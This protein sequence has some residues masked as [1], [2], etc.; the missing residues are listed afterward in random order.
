MLSGLFTDGGL[1]WLWSRLLLTEREQDTKAKQMQRKV[2]S[3]KSL[4]S[5]SGHASM[6]IPLSF[7]TSPSPSLPKSICRQVFDRES[8]WHTSALLAI[9]MESISL[10]SRLYQFGG[11]G[12]GSRAGFLS[13]IEAVLN[14]NGNQKI[15]SVQMSIADPATLQ[16]REEKE[17]SNLGVRGGNSD[18]R[19]KMQD[20]PNKESDY[21]ATNSHLAKL[22]INFLPPWSDQSSRR[23]SHPHRG[24]SNRQIDCYDHETSREHLFGQV[25]TMRGLGTGG[26]G[27]HDKADQQ[28]ALGDNRTNRMQRRIAV[29]PTLEK[30]VIFLTVFP[31]L[32][33]WLP[34]SPSFQYRLS[35]CLWLYM[36][37][38]A[39]A[40]VS[41]CLC[42]VEFTVRGD[43]TCMQTYTSDIPPCPSPRPGVALRLQLSG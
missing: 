39:Y 40:L 32:T 35:P 31:Y 14:G 2:N 36:S 3:A 24:H 27:G 42:F 11:N 5:L 19:M 13:N 30:Y 10:P 29:L 20:R 37:R 34:T 18:G 12:S 9:V 22:D 43:G 7:P 17:I 25:E 21:S 26:I 6:Y 15:S 41:M 4:Y 28:E 8:L 33:P 1:R 23:A 16:T 38:F